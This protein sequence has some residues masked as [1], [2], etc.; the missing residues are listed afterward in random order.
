MPLSPRFRLVFIAGI[1]LGFTIAAGCAGCDDDVTHTSDR[2]PDTECEPCD[3]HDDC[4]EGTFCGEDDGEDVCLVQ[5]CEPESS[6]CDG[7]AVERCDDAGSQWLDPVDCESGTC[8]GGECVCGDDTDCAGDQSCID[9]TCQCS[10]GE[11]CGDDGACCGDGEVCATIEVCDEDDEC[12]DVTTCQPECPGEICG[13]EGEVCCEGDEPICGPH[14]DCAPDCGDDSPLCG[15]DFDICCDAG[16][17][18]MFGECVTPGDPCDDVTECGFDEYCEPA[19]GQCVPAAFPDDIE[20]REE[21]EFDD[22]AIEQKWSWTDEDI[23]STPVVGDVTGDDD[24]NVVVNATRME[25]GSWPIGNIYILDSG[26]NELHK[27]EHDPDNDEWGSHGRSNIALADVTGDNQMEIIYA[28]RGTGGESY[29]VAVDGDGEKVWRA[30]NDGGDPVTDRLHNGAITT[31]NFDGDPDRAQIVMGAMLIDHDG[32]VVWHEHSGGTPFGS[33]QGYDG[34]VPVVADI[35]G[36]GDQEI[37]TG[38][39]AWSVDWQTSGDGTPDVNVEHL[40]QHDGPDGYP[41]V[42]DIDGDGT[43]EVVLVASSTVRILDG[44]TGD[45]WCGIDPGGDDCDED[46][47]LR[48]QPIALPGPSSQN[49]GGPPTVADF[50]GDG[51]PEIGVAG[52]HYYAV[53]DVNRLSFG[54][55]DTPEDVD[56]ELLEQF[57][58]PDPDP[59]DIYVRWRRET[60][61]LSS[62]ATGSSVFDFQGDGSASVVYADECFM[63][64][65]SGVDGEFELEVMNSTGTILEYPVIVDV[66]GNGRS[67]ILVVAN[68]I[69][70]CS[71]LFDGYETRQGITAYEDPNE[72]WVHT[73]SIWNQHAYSIDNIEDDGSQPAATPNWWD[74]HNTFRANR[75]GEIPLNAPDV[76]VTSLQID[77]TTCMAGID[78]QATVENQGL[79]VIPAGLPVSLYNVTS[80]EL[81]ETVVLDEAISPGAMVTVQFT[82]ELTPSEINVPLEYRVVANDE[83]AEDGTLSPDCNP[84]K[85]DSDTVEINCESAG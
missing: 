78:F 52:G 53:F 84:D 26:G 67:E 1:I 57:D 85:A 64:V 18:C 23:I 22:L 14:G 65:Y 33:N 6:R 83:D 20:C 12:Q 56:D 21:G 5:E 27:V 25:G 11:L 29:V 51:R 38:R 61:D 54:D 60:Q 62:N 16:D 63:R 59:G 9:G 72:R 28:S 48:T 66:D 82:H 2:C 41:A 80:G 19:V 71:D 8:D 24:P 49:R 17:L 50:D 79:Q 76:A 35:D 47:S 77:A 4:G 13:F 42:A 36:S 45:L 75:Q 46:E 69:D 44:E 81:L 74:T 55:D 7:G 39:D 3:D 70:H 37:I 40:W 73:R 43:P 31:A 30:R 10:T 68:D 32:T 58:E 34:G 15:D